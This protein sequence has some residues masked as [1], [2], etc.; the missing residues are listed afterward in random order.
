MSFTASATDVS[1]AV[2]S[3]GFTYAWTFGD[4]STGTGATPSHT[5]TTA[6]T[7]TVTVT[8]TDEYGKTGTATESMVVA[9]S[10][11][12]LTVSAGSN[13]TANAGSTATFAGSVSG[14]TAP[15]TYSWNFGDGTTTCR[16][17][18]QLR[19]HR[20]DDEG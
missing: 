7:Y 3:A 14:G 11:S 18:G 5:Y 15:Y 20:Y 1:P 6:G 9:S 8:A 19:E 10:P 4:G 17:L 2:Q 13:V 16:E 12:G